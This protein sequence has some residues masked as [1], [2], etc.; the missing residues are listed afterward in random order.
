MNPSFSAGAAIRT[1]FTGTFYSR[2]DPLRDYC[3]WR[4]QGGGRADIGSQLYLDRV[5]E[6]YTLHIHLHPLTSTHTGGEIRKIDKS[7]REIHPFF[8]K[9][10]VHIGTIS[11]CIYDVWEY[12]IEFLGNI[13]TKDSSLLLH[14]IQSHFYWWILKKTILFSGLKIPLKKPRYKKTRVYPWIA[15]CRTEKWW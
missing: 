4:G 13:L 14:Y 11:M 9:I 10:T 3:L 7:S 1:G 12:M 15:F 2:I 5:S 8:C 6:G